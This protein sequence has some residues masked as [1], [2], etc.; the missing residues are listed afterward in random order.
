MAIEGKVAAVLNTRELV[1][2]RGADAGVTVGTKFAVLGAQEVTD[3]D[4]NR[5][6]G[7]LHRE[8]IRVEVV[9]VQDNMA[10]ARTYETYLPDDVFSAFFPRST[11]VTYVRT[12]RDEA[13]SPASSAS[14]TG[15]VLVQRG[16]RVRQV[17]EQQ[18]SQ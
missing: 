9:E 13:Q 11:R 12:L 6:L 15:S 4:T 1:I 7:S 16:D 14:G 18:S 3:P 10:V 8:K 17:E 5:P 2:N